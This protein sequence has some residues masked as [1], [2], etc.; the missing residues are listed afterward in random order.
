M[1]NKTKKKM[2]YPPPA[3]NRPFLLIAVILACLA[4]TGLHS[5]LQFRLINAASLPIP[6]G[7]PLP[8]MDETSTSGYQDNVR[9][10]VLPRIAMD[11]YFWTLHTQ[12]LAASGALRLRETEADNSPDGREVH[13]SQ[14]PMWWTLSLAHVERLF[15][16]RTLGA[17]IEAASLWSNVAAFALLLA[18]LPWVVRR[19]LGD[20]V[21]A[22]FALAL[23]TTYTFFEGFMLGNFDHHGIVSAAA[24]CA[25]LFV[26]FGMMPSTTP[27]RLSDPE[28]G[29]AWFA[30][31]GFA[32]AFGL[33]I[34][35]STM[36]PT[37]LA[38]GFGG[39]LSTIPLRGTALPRSSAWR[40]FG[41]TT[42]LASTLFYLIEYFPNHLGWH[43][44]VNHPLYAIAIWGG[45]ETLAR[46]HGKIV[47]GRSFAASPRGRC[48]A[49]LAILAAFF[50]VAA[51]LIGGS[52][53]FAVSDPFLW[54]LHDSLI[55]EFM[56]LPEKLSHQS[57]DSVLFAYSLM[58]L[59]LIG[60]CALL[61]QDHGD[62]RDKAAL[63]IVAVA[64]VGMTALAFRQVRWLGAAHALWIPVLVIW[65]SAISRTDLL[66]PR[67]WITR[68]AFGL[69]LLT[70]FCQFP[71]AL[72]RR[73]LSTFGQEQ[74]VPAKET[75]R[76]VARE[77]AWQIRSGSKDVS[78]VV[79]SS[80]SM[81]LLMLY[82][83]GF[84]GVS[85]F[86]WENLAG[87][88]AAVEIYEAT[89]AESAR[90]LLM[91]RGVTHIVLPHLRPWTTEARLLAT[92]TIPAHK[93]FV[94]RLFEDGEIPEWLEPS[95]FTPPLG[96][97]ID[98]HSASIFAVRPNLTRRDWLAATSTYLN[99]VGM[100]RQAAEKLRELV[101]LDPAPLK[102]RLDLAKVELSLG[103][104]HEAIKQLESALKTLP[105]SEQ[106]HLMVSFAAEL[107]RA[108]RAAA[109]ATVLKTCIKTHRSGEAARDLAWLLAVSKDESV[110]NGH[111][112]LKLATALA[113]SDNSAA[114]LLVLAAAHAETGDFLQAIAAAERAHTIE[115]RANG[116][117]LNPIEAAIESLRRK[118]PIRE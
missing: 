12:N 21:A 60:V 103:N 13:W 106:V 63:V 50:P 99:R 38:L 69:A 29:K 4:L 76:V 82:Y 23:A 95:L 45:S 19:K 72:F 110:R 58:P 90:H 70:L 35:A 98:Q 73:A 56:S 55:N 117:A 83:G 34:S 53:V 16:G 111:E 107:R 93:G 62:K 94:A 47:E 97:G 17:A 79:L 22:A 104:E 15:S 26:A 64:A 57:I 67:R 74:G 113:R 24:M 51:I 39:I 5:I 6:G 18:F 14:A 40:I 114:T 42:A 8:P 31:A 115:K 36:L 43:L 7:M 11:G 54:K 46:F 92:P 78:P 96:N 48:L 49:A 27:N 65:L 61:L 118:M 105:A 44:E 101:R 9:T 84:R 59:C 91:A 87:L 33:W 116:D 30:A 52:S 112:A 108:G 1:M 32:G 28:T 41:A 37:L 80:P 20:S 3:R 68:T 86:Y 10:N 100:H 25:T 85:T 71:Q 88:R 66:H 102:P 77:L 89:D 109:A 81:T 75:E 2:D